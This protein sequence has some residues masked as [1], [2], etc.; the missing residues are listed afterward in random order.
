[1]REILFRIKD[2]DDWYY[3]YPLNK[4]SKNNIVSFQGKDENGGTY[5]NA[6]ADATTLTEFTGLTDKNG[7]MI[8]EGDIVQV[9]SNLQGTEFYI[10]AIEFGN[11]DD[12]NGNTYTG[13]YIK[14]HN[15]P[16]YSTLRQS[17][18]WWRDEQDRF[19]KV[20]GNIHD[21]PELLNVKE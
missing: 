12:Y 2:H 19:L 18:I 3:G 5:F 17:I 15:V 21:N 8:F 16:E 20:I 7:N 9:P 11:F 10:G 4:I 13:F 6:L 14:W 1:M